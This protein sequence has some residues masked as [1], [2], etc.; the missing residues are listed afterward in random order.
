MNDRNN[1]AKKNPLV[2]IYFISQRKLSKEQILEHISN[3]ASKSHSHQIYQEILKIKKTLKNEDALKIN[4]VF[5]S[6]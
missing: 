3:T 4:K 2:Q 6:N 1:S 5:I